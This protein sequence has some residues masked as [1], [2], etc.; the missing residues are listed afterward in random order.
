MSYDR[1]AKHFGAATITAPDLQESC[2]EWKRVVRTKRINSEKKGASV[3]E[4]SK[5]SQKN[6]THTLLCC[7]EDVI[8]CNDCRSEENFICEQCDIPICNECWRYTLLEEQIPKALCN[9]NFTGYVHEFIVQ[10]KVRWIEATIAAPVFTGLVTYYIEGH[11]SERHHLMEDVVGKPVRAVGVRGNLFSFLLPWTKV[12]QQLYQRIQQGDLSDWPLSR[13]AIAEIV[14]VRLVKGP[15]Q[16]INKFHDLEIRSSVVRKLAWLYIHRHQQDLAQ[17]PGVLKIHSFMQGPDVMSS[18]LA[19]V[20]ARLAKYY[21]E[22]E[23]GGNGAVMPEIQEMVAEQKQR[24][25]EQKFE[26]AFEMKQSTM[27]DNA[28]SEAKLFANVRPSVVTDEAASEGTFRTED[29]I[30]HSLQAVS[31]MPIEMS[32]QFEPQFVS[33]YMSRIFPWA[34]NYDC[35]GPEFPNLFTKL[36]G[37]EDVAQNEAKRWRRVHG[38]AVLLSG[39]YAAMVAT[40]PEAQIAGDWM[41]VPAARNLHWKHTVLRSSFLTCKQK[42]APGEPLE[43]NLSEL[44][45]ATRSIFNRIRKNTIEINRKKVNMNGD[46]RMIFSADDVT[47]TEK[48]ILS[49]FLNTTASIPGCQQIRKKIGHLCFGLRVVHGEVLFMTVSINRRFSTMILKLFRGRVNDLSFAAKDPSS[50]ARKKFCGKDTPAMF[51]GSNVADDPDGE[52]LNMELKL[53]EL[54]DRQA[55]NAQDPLSSMHQYLVFMYIVLPALVGLRMCLNC[56][57]CNADADQRCCSKAKVFACQDYLG[58]N[59][60]PHGGFAG[61]AAA[62]GFATEF[63]GDGTPHGHGFVS[64][65]NMYQH[66]TL[67]EIGKLIEENLKGFTAEEMLKRVT[68]F[69]EHVQQE[70]HF[71]NELHQQNLD[72]LER[73]FHNNNAGPLRNQY[74]SVRPKCF[75]ETN[76]K[77]YLWH[78]KHGQVRQEKTLTLVRETLE[79]AAEFRRRFEADV[80]FIFSRVQHHWH[81]FNA[82]GKREPMK[83]CRQVKKNMKRCKRDFPKTVM[84]DG[85][86]RIRQDRYRTRIVCKGVAAELKL[87]VSGRRNALGSF[88]MKRRCEWF[89]GTSALLAHVARSNTNVQCNYRVPIT[90]KTHDKDCKFGTCTKMMQTR[91]LAILAQRAMKQMTGYFGGYISKRQKVGQFEIKKSIGALPPFQEKLHERNLRASAQLSHVIMRMFTVLESKGILRA[92]TEETFLSALHNEDDPLSAEF[93]RTF[94]SQSFMGKYYIER[95][96]AACKKESFDVRFALPKNAVAKEMWDVAA[97]YGFRSLHP[98]TLYMTPWL[99]VQ[100]FQHILLLA[101]CRKRGDLTKWT[102]AGK[103]KYRNAVIQKCVSDVVFIAGEDYELDPTKL[104]GKDYYFPYPDNPSLFHGKV[105]ASY[106]KFRHTWILRRRERPVVPCS[107]ATPMPSRRKSKEFRS[108]IMSVYHRPWTLFP[109]LDNSFVPYV[110]DLRFT[111]AQ[112]LQLHT[113]KLTQTE[114]DEVEPHL[115]PDIRA[116][117]KEHLRTL[118][119]HTFVQTRNFLMASI[120]EGRSFEEEEKGP[121]RGEA[122][123]APFTLDEVHHALKLDNAERQLSATG[124]NL[125]D[126]ENNEIKKRNKRSKQVDEA[127]ALAEQLTALIDVHGE[128]SVVKT[129]NVCQN[130]WA[131]VIEKDESKSDPMVERKA[132]ATLKSEPWMPLFQAWAKE[133]FENQE[134]MTPNVK[135]KEILDLV[136][137]RRLVEFA[138]ENGDTENISSQCPEPLLRLIHGLP[139]SGKTEVLRWIQSYFETVWQWTLGEEFVFLA[140]LNSMASNICGFTLHSWGQIAF[141][142]KRGAVMKP[143]KNDEEVSSMALQCTRVRFLF[144]DEVEAA[145]AETIAKLESNMRE[146]VSSRNRWC[147]RED[148]DTRRTFGGVNVFFLGDFWQLTPTGQIAIMGNLYGEKVLE[149]EHALHVMLMFWKADYPD[150]VQVW[151]DDSKSRVIDLTVNVRSGADKWFSDLLASCRLGE[152]CEDDYNFLHGFPTTTAITFWWAKAQDK[153][154]KHPAWCAERRNAT[155]FSWK[156]NDTKAPLNTDGQRFECAVC[157]QERKRRC[158]VLAVASENQTATVEKLND[159]HFAESTYITSFNKA[160][161]CY[162]GNRSRKF[163]EAKNEQLFWITATDTPQSWFAS[164]YSKEQLLQ[165]QKRWAHYHARKCEGILS[166]LPACYKMPYT[167]THSH[168][169]EFQEYGIFKGARGKLMGWLLDEADQKKI[170]N[171]EDGDIVLTMLPKIPS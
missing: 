62:M 171:S 45:I 88:A 24:P 140:P 74:L 70:D 114:T 125:S 16:I 1:Y 82:K 84:R 169:Q 72:E 35:G 50:A 138:E 132:R 12:M 154:W 66:C 67:E 22:S 36:A 164:G 2:F 150:A 107:E 29:L 120:A 100:W 85:S 3:A 55:M 113:T 144:I 136:H 101:P 15:E 142:D 165:M 135:Q 7:P 83:Y 131:H 123:R 147:Y 38:E 91:R 10:A 60:K 23:Y 31:R 17:R 20:D 102:V 13:K 19:H 104:R 155:P 14:R 95:F 53:P 52:V 26:S 163:A 128:R 46:I 109:N 34:L 5:S 141:K 134:S 158:R 43:K 110:S 61:L 73:D 75:S 32:N 116:A 121:T 94:R 40:R 25:S 105:P 112:L 54:S 68:T 159:V 39:P 152:M 145:G 149:N 58:S 151:N 129:N 56:P 126:D 6:N 47:A 156:H 30:D 118:L 42:V 139:G 41:L 103:Q 108:K 90:E 157:F 8:A 33:Q 119:P 162:A 64:L 96:E 160:V 167:V 57:H 51:T 79:E 111:Q 166:I 71:D 143:R 48:T 9:D 127:T 153:E 92:A 27:P 106:T 63:Q 18:L 69:L 86:G 65:S 170:A 49:S 117:W 81:P 168:G 59:M 80:Q 93:I 21:P 148:K 99:F 77:P 146:N 161:F 37:D 122:L 87:A 76:D 98:D 130:K 133:V 4:S 124:E 89:S 115:L 137:K 78:E 97:G 44:V 11:P 28:E